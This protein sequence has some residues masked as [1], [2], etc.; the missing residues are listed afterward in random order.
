MPGTAAL[1]SGG[2]ASVNS[3]SCAA[4]G[5]CAAGGYYKDGSDHYQ[6][7]VVNSAPGATPPC[8]VPN[9]VGETLA[10]AKKTLTASHCRVGTIKKIYRGQR[11]G[12]S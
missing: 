10:A 6:A 4:A 1:N 9:L 3:V 5:D 8:V 11:R 2:D 12:T 7:F